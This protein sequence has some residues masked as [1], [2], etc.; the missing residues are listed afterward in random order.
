VC[1]LPLCCS[2]QPQLLPCIRATHVSTHSYYT[3][4]HTHML[5]R[6]HTCV[7]YTIP[8]TITLLSVTHKLTLY[9]PVCRTP[10]RCSAWPQPAPYGRAAR[11]V[12]RG[13]GACCYPCGPHC[14]HSQPRG[15][16]L[17][18]SIKCDTCVFVCV[19]VCACSCVRVCACVCVCVC[20]CVCVC[21]CVCVYAGKVPQ[22]TSLLAFSLWR[23]CCC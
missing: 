9:A 22:L 19:C 3:H 14:A 11:R 20:M 18:W 1:L 23:C 13:E 8:I 5:T 15:G 17:L 6:P 10:T 16:V 2:A 21:V 12:R 4:T 7:S